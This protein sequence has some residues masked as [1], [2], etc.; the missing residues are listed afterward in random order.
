MAGGVSAGAGELSGRVQS[1]WQSVRRARYSSAAPRYLATAV[2]FGFFALG[3][4][5]ALFPAAAAAPAVQVSRGADAPSEDFALQFARAYLSYDA[6]APGER[7]R[8]L[9]PFLSTQLAGGAGFTPAAGSQRVLWAEVASDQPAL[10][11]GRVIT[12]AA[13]VSTQRLPLYLAVTVRHQAGQPLALVG[14][15]SLVGAPAVDTRAAAPARSAVTEAA[16]LEVVDRVLRNYL[17]GAAPNLQ[18][19]LTADAVVTLPT[20]AL[21]VQNVDQVAW[22]AGPGS[23]A[24]LATV[25]AADSRG[26]AYTLTYELGIAYRERPYVDFIEVVPTST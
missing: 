3:V 10:A 19:D 23:G 1:G 13:S 25:T 21:R 17:A 24:V 9:A 8:A 4:R 18:A 12:V 16:V 11:G 20:V 26:N 5:T 22:V 7:E 2:L 14:Y 6:A 15:P